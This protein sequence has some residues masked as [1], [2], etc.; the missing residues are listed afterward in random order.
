VRERARKGM[1]AIK[2]VGY[3]MVVPNTLKTQ[4]SILHETL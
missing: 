3:I 4:K 1:C 2:R